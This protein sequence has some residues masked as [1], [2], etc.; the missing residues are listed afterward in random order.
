MKSEIL[1]LG[2]RVS[3]VVKD[4]EK[5]YLARENQRLREMN[6]RLVEAIIKVP[7]DEGFEEHTESP[8]SVGKAVRSRSQKLQ[9]LH[10]RASQEFKEFIE[11]Q[12]REN[13]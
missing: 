1:A 4:P 10:E 12:R 7:E 11:K 13:A 8:R 5:E 3:V 2:K 9:L 6:E